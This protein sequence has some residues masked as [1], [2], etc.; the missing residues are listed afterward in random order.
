LVL[1]KRGGFAKKNNTLALID[2]FRTPFE[3]SEK[4]CVLNAK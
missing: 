2:F 3:R 1:G 4:Q